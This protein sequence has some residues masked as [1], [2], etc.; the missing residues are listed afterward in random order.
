MGAAMG[1]VVALVALLMMMRRRFPD[2]P[3]LLL[4]HLILFSPDYKRKLYVAKQRLL[5]CP[6]LAWQTQTWLVL[7]WQHQSSA[8]R[9]YCQGSIG[10]HA[11]GQLCLLTCAL[12]R[13]KH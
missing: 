13:C 3:P 4:P 12:Q 10:C 2:G 8:H 11:P 5:R 9:W 1:I 6:P 7:T